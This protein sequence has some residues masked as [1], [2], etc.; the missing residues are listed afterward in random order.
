MLS[1]VMLI[2]S[3]VI[4]YKAAEME[5]RNVSLW[6]SAT[7]LVCIGC[8]LVIPLGVISIFIGLVLCFGT[9]FVLTLSGR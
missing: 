2:A 7:L 3:V 5:D 6:A 1:L 9:M 4:M 8:I